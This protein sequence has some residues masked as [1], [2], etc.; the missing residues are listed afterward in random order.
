M[1]T[2]SISPVQRLNLGFV[3]ALGLSIKV[4]EGVG[5]AVKIAY[6]PPSVRLT[7][8][9]NVEGAIVDRG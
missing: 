8:R 4:P 1:R 9:I 7:V 6:H 5:A 3:L 2:P